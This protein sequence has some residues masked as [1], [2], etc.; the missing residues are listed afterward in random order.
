MTEDP[1]APPVPAGIS[2]T[3]AMQDYLKAVY[4]L[5]DRGAVSTQE[6]A[7]ELG[8]AAPSV[9]NM[10]KRMHELGLL[11]HVPYQGV[12]LTAAGRHAALDVIRRHRLLET[13]LA[14]AVG[15][16]WDE[17]HDEAE[18]LEHH[19]SDR[20]EARLDSLLG[21]PATDPRGDPIPREGTDLVPGPTLLE[22]PA[23]AQGT[24][25]RVSDR[26]PEQLRYLGSLGIVPGA[27]VAVLEHLPFEGPVRVRVLTDG[28]EGK[29]HV[30]GRILAEAVRLAS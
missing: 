30:L 18:R 3:P 6:L 1:A 5:G 29:E 4:R 17:V 19:L 25:S 16:G 14:E 15:L 13:Y 2:I 24:V 8:V 7:D 11:H 28:D 12:S 22:T 20:L 21:F 26:D 9:T 23:G 27:K 10:A